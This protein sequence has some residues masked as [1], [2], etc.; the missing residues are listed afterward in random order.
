MPTEKLVTICVEGSLIHYTA[1]T[2]HIQAFKNQ[3]QTFRIKFNFFFFESN[4][5]IGKFY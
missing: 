1:F 2:L 5:N 4:S 3:I